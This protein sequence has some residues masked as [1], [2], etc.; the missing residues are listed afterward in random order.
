MP[1]DK[2]AYLPAE[3]NWWAAG[4]T[5]PCGPDTEIF[6]WVGEGL[7]PFDSNK[8]TDSDNWMEIWNNVFMQYNRIDADTL[9][10]LPSPCVDTGMGL[11]RITATLNGKTTVYDT[12]IF[13]EALSTIKK[14]VG[15]ENYKETSARIIADHVRSATHMISDGVTPKNIDQGYILRRLI[16][17][18]IREFYKM[19]HEQ[20]ALVTIADVYIKEFSSVYGSIEKNQDIIRAELRKEEEKFGKTL[21][22]GVREFDKISRTLAVGSEISGSQAFTLFDT[23]GFP[24]EMTGEIAKEKGLT[25]D[26]E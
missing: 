6:W 22:Q 7:P 13:R 11:E 24:V 19:G 3:D 26:I 1:V 14:I 18:A 9:I 15:E 2:I 16:R 4:P 5:G 23:Y 10:P 12:N 8:G 25:V 21:S 20:A 17:R